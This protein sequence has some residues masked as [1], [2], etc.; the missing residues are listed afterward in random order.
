MN[1][2]PFDPREPGPEAIRAGV[3]ALVAGRNARRPEYHWRWMPEEDAPGTDA[4]VERREE[5]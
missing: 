5:A 4:D 1:A 2:E 3:S